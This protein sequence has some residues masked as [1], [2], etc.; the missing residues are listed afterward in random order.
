MLKCRIGDGY[1]AYDETPKLILGTRLTDKETMLVQVRSRVIRILEDTE[2]EYTTYT[3]ET[4]DIGE[5]DYSDV[6]ANHVSDVI[7]I[8]GAQITS[9]YQ[10]QRVGTTDLQF[11]FIKVYLISDESKTQI[12]EGDIIESDGSESMT[13]EVDAFWDYD[14]EDATV[15][16]NSNVFTVAYDNTT[17]RLTVTW[18]S[19]TPE[20]IGNV[21]IRTD[22]QYIYFVIRT[23]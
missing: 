9:A 21:Y 18:T 16:T 20:E 10:H 22:N 15:T 12:G 17:Q 8:S 13:F 2:K 23:V 19:Q 14:Y 5:V 4:S 1:G 6:D 7:N 3:G 11:R